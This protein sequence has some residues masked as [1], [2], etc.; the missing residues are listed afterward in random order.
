MQRHWYLDVSLTLSLIGALLIVF[1][2]DARLPKKEID[3]NENGSETETRTS[4]LS[5]NRPAKRHEPRADSIYAERVA[6]NRIEVAQKHGG[7]PI[8]EKAVNDGLDW[9]SRHQAQEGY[10]SNRCLGRAPGSMCEKGSPCTLR[11]ENFEIAT[12]GL[13]L[14]AFQGGGHFWFNE[15][16]YSTQV[17]R[18]LNW[19]I[20]K[21][22]NNGRFSSNN[23]QMN[24]QF[25]YEHAI[26]TFALAEAC[27]LA[28]DSNQQV[29]EKYQEALVRAVKFIEECQNPYRGGWRYSP[30]EGGDSSV[31]GWVV[32]ALK[33]AI[34]GDV[35]VN[36]NCLTQ[37]KKFF[38][39]LQIHS[40]GRTG[41][42]SASSFI[43]EAT[44]GVGM[45]VQYFLEEKIDADFLTAASNYLAGYAQ[46]SWPKYNQGKPTPDY[47]LWYNGTLGMYLTGG[48]NWDIWNDIV[49]DSLTKLQVHTGCERGSWPPID[50][51]GRSGGRIY[52]T[53]LAILTLEVYYRFAKKNKQGQ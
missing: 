51:W 19:L 26:A 42:T 52:S 17:K 25:M 32:L 20:S 33:S 21:Q 44:T 13:A 14:L 4:L 41:Y 18:G 35:P 40:T 53:A 24:S 23:D 9:L 3:N 50:Q 28:K 10:W 43:T 15:A 16:A 49:R 38:K 8:S 1:F 12:T 11:G 2:V 47:Y 48:E 39:M 36:P 37:C 7:S 22:L 45:L 30:K 46:K 31:S 5:A 34:G 6:E 27:A 29:D